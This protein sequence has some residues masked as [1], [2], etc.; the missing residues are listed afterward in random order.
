MQGQALQWTA[1]LGPVILATSPIPST[2]VFVLQ[3]PGAL[4]ILDS[5]AHL[6]TSVLEDHYCQLF[7][8]LAY[9]V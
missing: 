2:A 8:P 3:D 9:T 1:V 5:L 7:A 6:D 4:Q